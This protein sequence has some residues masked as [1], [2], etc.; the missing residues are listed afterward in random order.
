VHSRREVVRTRCG[1]K[2]SKSFIEQSALARGRFARTSGEPRTGETRALALF[3]PSAL[4]VVDL[5]GTVSPAPRE[6]WAE[7]ARSGRASGAAA[8]EPRF[9][10]STVG[11]PAR[12]GSITSRCSIT[13]VV[14]TRRP[15]DHPSGVRTAIRPGRTVKLSTEPEQAHAL[16]QRRRVAWNR[17][18]TTP[19][20]TQDAQG[21]HSKALVPRIAARRSG[22]EPCDGPAV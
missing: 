17:L 1:N 8:D 5:R 13:S 6:T 20:I 19:A 2:S 16:Q 18:Q 14:V 10:K 7:S 9:A 4:E 12:A 11:S 3:V 21:K 15:P 22:A